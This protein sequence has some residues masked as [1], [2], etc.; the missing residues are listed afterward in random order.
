VTASLEDVAARGASAVAALRDAAG[1]VDKLLFHDGP[2][3]LD[4]ESTPQRVKERIVADADRLVRLF[5][6]HRLI[7]RRLA[8][9]VLEARRTR[10]GK[11]V[12]V[13]DVGA[14]AGGLLF[15]LEDWARRERVSVELRGLDANAGHVAAARRTA[16]EEGRR[17]D[18]QVGDGTRLDGVPDEGVDLAVSTLTLHHLEPGDA[19][20]MLAELDRVAA[21]SFF[22]FDL[23]RNLAS[24]PALWA[25]LRLG[26]FDAPTRHDALTSLRRAYRAEELRS[27][28]GAAEIR[29]AVVEEIPPAFVVATRG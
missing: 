20:R 6:L 7:N 10:R 19:A 29:D 22:A 3:L 25:F 11:P 24:L 9:L 12:R 8:R 28:L 16:G 21:V 5:Q 26:G 4:L 18:F 23:R 13:L 27:L 14:G 17:V 15:R 1:T 2:E